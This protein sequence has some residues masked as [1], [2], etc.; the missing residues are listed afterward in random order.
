MLCFIVF[1]AH[2]F[3]QPQLN[4]FLQIPEYKL[5]IKYIFFS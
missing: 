1:D 5:Q 3:L 2:L 4:R